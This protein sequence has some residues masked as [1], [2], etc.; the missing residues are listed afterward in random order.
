MRTSHLLATLTVATLGFS[1][2]SYAVPAAPPSNAGTVNNGG[3]FMTY[4]ENLAGFPCSGGNIA[5]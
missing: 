3:L 5:V 2:L 1:S 4:F